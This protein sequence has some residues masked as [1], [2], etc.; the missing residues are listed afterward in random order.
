MSCRSQQNI[1]KYPM[2]KRLFA[3]SGAPQ[4]GS[5]GV[6]TPFVMWFDDDSYISADNPH[7]WLAAVKHE[8]TST[9]MLGS[10][11]SIRLKGNQSS[12]VMRQPWYAGLPVPHL[13]RT[14]YCTGGWWTIRTDLLLKFQWPIPELVHRGGDV[15]L[16]E[17]FRQQ[18]LRITHFREGVAINADADGTESNSPRRGY[19][20]DPIGFE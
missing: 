13:H 7:E 15:M 17:L 11:Y 4:G 12:W 5:S 20:S 9:D 2:M 14:S 3:S 19:D 1:K 10:V 16:G 18:R 8:M 6:A